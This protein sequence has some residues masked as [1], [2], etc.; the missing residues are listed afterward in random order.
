LGFLTRTAQIAGLPDQSSCSAISL[1]ALGA[2][3]ALLAASYTPSIPI[4]VLDDK[5]V[6]GLGRTQGGA[7]AAPR[8]QFRKK[9]Q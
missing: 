1:I 2:K 5:D 8:A 6:Y 7:P 4:R 9:R 3:V